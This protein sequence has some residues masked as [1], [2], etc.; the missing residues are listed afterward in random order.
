MDKK[1]IKLL[2]YIYNKYKLML[3]LGWFSYFVN[4]YYSNSH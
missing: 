1:K 4:K 3:K 2:K